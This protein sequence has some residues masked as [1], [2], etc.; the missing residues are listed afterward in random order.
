MNIWEPIILSLKVATISTIF[1][2]IIGT[3]F[4]HIFT[5]YNFPFKD[6]LEVIFTLP[7]TIPPTIVGYLLLILLGRRGPV[8][9]FLE[10]VFGIRII[11]TWVAACIA[12]IVVSLPLMYQS[13]KSSLQGVNPVYEKAAKTLGV[14]NIKIFFKITVPLALPGI[15]S[16]IVLSFSRALGEFGATLMVAGNIPGKTETIPLAIYYAVE[17]NNKEKAN[18]LMLIVIIFSFINIYLLNKWLKK[19][20]MN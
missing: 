13:I 9:I 14:S 2:L 8:G 3:F 16:G 10:E 12:S 5:K 11:F 15:V 19:K 6:G 7:M 1:T 18:T 4:A 17:S 20:R